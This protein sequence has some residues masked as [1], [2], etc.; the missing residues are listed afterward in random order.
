MHVRTHRETVRRISSM[1]EPPASL[2]P[3][4]GIDPPALP[5]PPDPAES[6]STSAD[7]V[8]AVTRIDRAVKERRDTDQTFINWWLYTLVVSWVT[9]GIYGIVLF[10]KRINR[11]DRFSARKRAYYDA[12]TDWT[13]RYAQQHGQEDDIHHLLEDMRSDADTAYKG[14]LRNV[15]AGVSFLLTIITLGIYYFFVLYRLSRYWWDAMVL[16][17]EF[18]DKLSQAW[19]KLNITRYP[20]SFTLDQSKRRSFGLYLV[21]TFVT[22]GIWLYVWDYKVHTD[23]E[24]IYKEFHSIED[25]VLATVRSH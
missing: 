2:T 24:N 20:I 18:D 8:Q 7:L 17:Q 21:L 19:T 12:L 1:S 11:V 16:E 5:T 10:F 9:L 4:G 6:G 15:N 22:F 14:N 25:T 13:R 23:P 3:D